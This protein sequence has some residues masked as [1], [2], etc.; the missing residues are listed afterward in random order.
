MA[1][2]SHKIIEAFI[3]QL[4]KSGDVKYVESQA[5]NSSGAASSVPPSSSRPSARRHAPLFPDCIDA[6]EICEH[7]KTAELLRH[8]MASSPR[9]Q[10]MPGSTVDP[11]FEELCTIDWSLNAMS[12]TLSKLAS[13]RKKGIAAIVAGREDLALEDVTERADEIELAMSHALTLSK[14]IGMCLARR[15]AILSLIT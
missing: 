7:P 3:A 15:S 2:S 12:T 10:V 13:V 8:F 6:N 1:D 5:G 11:T 9:L 14:W 4:M